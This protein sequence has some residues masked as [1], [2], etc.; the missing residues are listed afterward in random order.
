MLA[1]PFSRPRRLL[2][3]E[4]QNE[5]RAPL[6]LKTLYCVTVRMPGPTQDATCAPDVAPD[7]MT[8]HFA[9]TR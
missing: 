4:A 8:D 9:S 2:R 7:P 5:S 6:L 1:L 3:A